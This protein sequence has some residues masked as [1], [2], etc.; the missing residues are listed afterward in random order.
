MYKQ[1]LNIICYDKITI[2]HFFPNKEFALAYQKFILPY[3]SK[4]NYKQ[5]TET[6]QQQVTGYYKALFVKVTDSYIILNGSLAKSL[7]GNNYYA[8]ALKDLKKWTNKL[9]D[10]FELKLSE[11]PLTSMEFS[12][13][14]FTDEKPEHYFKILGSSGKNK[15]WQKY[16]SKY[17]E[18][19]NR[20]II[21]YDKKKEVERRDHNYEL[22]DEIADKNV[23][24]FEVRYVKKLAKQL[25]RELVQ[26][27]DLYNEE[28]F[29]EMVE[30]YHHEYLQIHKN[31]LLQPTL[32]RMRCNDGKDYLLSYL[33]AEKGFNEVNE[34]VQQIKNRFTPVE[35]SR[36]KK[37]LKNLKYLSEPS[38]LLIELDNKIDE[39]INNTLKVNFTIE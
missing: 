33:I 31:N 14:V 32:G 1:Y 11:A 17:F 8:F 13:N 30:L 21:I 7:F 26:L 15:Q 12:G 23:L 24:R 34:T 37:A 22:C 39:L 38:P 4:S 19:T 16:T 27:K 2:K 9:D 18:G 36:F 25:G 29:K 35:H 6:G 10:E 3:L 20:N 28:F 5:D